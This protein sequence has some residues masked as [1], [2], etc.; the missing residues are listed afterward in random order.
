[1]PYLIP[2][3]LSLFILS[4]LSAHFPS[5]VIDT[6]FQT[7]AGFGHGFAGYGL[8]SGFLTQPQP[9]PPAAGRAG[10][11]PLA[12]AQCR[13]IQAEFEIEINE[14]DGGRR[15]NHD[16]HGQWRMTRDEGGGLESKG[17]TREREIQ[18]DTAGDSIEMR[19]THP[20]TTMPTDSNHPTHSQP[21][22]RA[23]TADSTMT[24]DSTTMADSVADA[25]NNSTTTV[26]AADNAD[27]GGGRYQ[28]GSSAVC[29][30]NER[31]REL[32]PA[33]DPCG[34]RDPRNPPDPLPKPA[35][36]PTRARGYGFPRVGVRV[37]L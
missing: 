3:P 37:G 11:R 34:L 25:A 8:G 12:A 29:I 20:Q 1:M 31:L 6:G 28:G 19:H 27:G 36:P 2:I 26:A 16:D 33:V 24:V 4:D 32:T 13:A 30:R 22:G 15:V 23:T 35:E 18:Q 7:R 17:K 14:V 21:G 5:L 10:A 9:V